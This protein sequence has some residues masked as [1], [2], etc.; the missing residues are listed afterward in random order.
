MFIRALFVPLV[1]LAGL[2]EIL[3]GQEPPD[4][5]L[6]QLRGVNVLIEPLVAIGPSNS[7]LGFDSLGLKLAA[8][9]RLAEAGV[10]VLSDSQWHADPSL[11][12]LDVVA[13][14][15]R[16]SVT[17]D[18]IYCVNAVVYQGVVADHDVRLLAAIWE[19]RVRFGRAS[20]ATAA[21]TLRATALLAIDAL[22]REYRASNPQRSRA[23]A[24]QQAD[25]PGGG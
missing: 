13:R 1:L 19:S 4:K 9:Q 21:E 10:R 3:A 7:G 5:A 14:V 18:F 20:V 11:P 6:T 2:A 8:E 23:V 15:Q 17:G 25:L 22:A 16:D 24:P 12:F